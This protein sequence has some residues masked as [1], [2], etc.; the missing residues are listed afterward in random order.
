M[1]KI[2]TKV[3]MV[4]VCCML[5]GL[6]SFATVKAD[7]EIPNTT[8]DDTEEIVIDENNIDEIVENGSTDKITVIVE[9][10]SE[11]KDWIVA[12]VVSFIGSGSF[13][14]MIL[15]IVRKISSNA[16]SKI[17][18]LEKEA[19]ISKEQAE[20]AREQLEIL[21]KKIETDYIPAMQKSVGIVNDYLEID[22]KKTEQVNEL[23]EKI[24]IPGLDFKEGTN[25]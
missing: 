14:G 25:E 4:V 6:V 12:F 7:D 17:K 8:D 19:K 1:K 11:I 24:V 5:I 2:I 13:F 15:A 22:K 18:E 9:K 3:V 20:L 21:T 23:L 10:A 16:N